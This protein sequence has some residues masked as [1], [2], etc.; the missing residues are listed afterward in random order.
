V[1]EVRVL[2]PPELVWLLAAVA[3]ADRAAFEQLYAATCAK[4][5]GVVLRILRQKD[6]ADEV[7]Q[8]VYLEIWSSAGQFNP[9]I[10][11]PITWAVAIARNHA[12]DR[13]RKKAEVTIEDESDAMDVVSETVDPAAG[14]QRTEE[15]KRLLACMGNLNA[16]RQRL[17]LLAYY[18]GWTREQLAA[19][20]GKP[21]QTV[22]AW[23]QRSLAE[24]LGSMTFEEAHNNEPLAAEYVLGTLDADER[25]QAQALLDTNAVFAARVR[26]WERRLGELNSM[27]QA[28]ELPAETWH[29]ISA[30]LEGVAASENFVLPSIEEPAASGKNNIIDFVRGFR[31]WREGTIVAGTVAATLAGFVATSAVAPDA[32]PA[33]LRPRPQ[34]VEVV[35]T[36]VVKPE[37]LPRF[38]AVLQQNN[39]SPAF[40][41]SV[42]I[43]G[44]SLTVRRVAADTQAGKSYELWLVSDRF[45]K[46]QS[47]GVV[48]DTDFAVDNKL[49]AYDAATI[50][51]ATYAVSL[52]P[53]GGS[54]TGVA[55]GPILWTGKLVQA[56]PGARRPLSQQSRTP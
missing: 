56:L 15:L 36:Q 46:P 53:E 8:E 4:L 41:L 23:L 27:V 32:M 17:V 43:E 45:P 12:I 55:T 6:L 21:V 25:A 13:V 7:I 31:Y 40:I 35:K 42:D 52:E 9:A 49:T 39:T 11:T 24:I 2:T 44:R 10:A 30:R 47:L 28:V 19:K 3:K 18:S 20:L 34:V 50:T 22:K 33:P 29:N 54:P 1:G 5:H 16:E 37:A 48:G 14:Q 38:V 26:Y 51:G